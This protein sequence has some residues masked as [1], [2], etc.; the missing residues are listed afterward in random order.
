MNALAAHYT[1]FRVA[2]RLLLTG[3]SHQAWPDRAFAGQVRAFADAADRVDG[4]WER[5]FAMAESVRTGFA[6]LLAEPGNERAYALAPST[7][8]LVVRFLSALPLAARPRLVT[9]DGEFHT[10]R[11]QLDRLAEEGVEVVKVPAARPDEVAARV[12]AAVDGR[13][14]AALVSSVL[15]A[16]G[17]IVEG[18]ERVAEACARHGAAL[19]LDAYHALNVLPFPLRALGLDGAYVVGGGYKYCQLGEGNCFLRVPAG[20]APRPVV[21]GW[22]AEFEALAE[23]A[24]G[25]VAYG[26]GGARFA[27]ATYDPTSHYRAAEV[28]A[29]FAEQGLDPAALREISQRQVGLLAAL[30]DALDLPP[31]IVDRD[32]DVP[33]AKTGGFLALRTPRAA[34]L[35]AAL[36]A[37]G[38]ATDFRDDRLRLGPAPYLADSQLEAAVAA[39]GEAARSLAPA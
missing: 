17:W 22:F 38:V 26:E 9:T 12:A 5:A 37:R 6:R 27:G 15:F 36:A 7:H 10:L 28:F 24:G 13:T 33:L 23:K 19:L 31:E 29:F 35:S 16:T 34:E 8:D 3:H 30:F 32:R 4:K 2:E 14:A 18:L 20:A 25:R 1:R 11:R 21:T 39:L